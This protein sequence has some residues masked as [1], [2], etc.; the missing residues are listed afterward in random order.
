VAAGRPAGGPSI[1][2]DGTPG[3]SENNASLTASLPIT[4][5]R[6]AEANCPASVVFPDPGR[7]LT[8][9]GRFARGDHVT[10]EHRPVGVPTRSGSGSHTHRHEPDDAGAGS[11]TYRQAAP[12]LTDKT[13][14]ERRVGRLVSS[15]GR[16]GRREGSIR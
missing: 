15:K 5:I 4:G 8:K 12:E 13:N 3:T 2:R 11:A 16:R 10:S 7:L 6:I 9:I 14:P 1:A